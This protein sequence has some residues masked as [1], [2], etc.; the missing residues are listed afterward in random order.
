MCV[1][2]ALPICHR[3]LPSADSCMGG[4]RRGALRRLPPL[5]GTIAHIARSPERRWAVLPRK[6]ILEC[7]NYDSSVRPSDS[8]RDVKYEIR[9]RLARRAH[10]LERLGY[11]IISLN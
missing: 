1:S 6:A 11:E 9:G 3:Y 8:L 4:G 2:D 5:A 7:M 10:E